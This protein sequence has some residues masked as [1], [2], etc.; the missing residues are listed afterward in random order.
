MGCPWRPANPLELTDPG[1]RD[2]HAF[3]GKQ[4]AFQGFAASVAAETPSSGN[5]AVAGHIAPPA[6]F[7][8]V[9]DRARRTRPPRQ[10]RHLTVSRDTPHRDFANDE[11]DSIGECLLHVLTRL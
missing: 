7:H 10:C 2:N 8:D 9:S 3:C 6:R 4:R 11:E 1:T 5:H